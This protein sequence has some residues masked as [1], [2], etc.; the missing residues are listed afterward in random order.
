MAK[1]K[2]QEAQRTCEDC[3]H[4]YACNMW[5]IGTLHNTDASGCGIYTTVKDSA[6]YLIGKMDG[7]KGVAQVKWERDKAIEQ[8][9]H[10]PNCGAKIEVK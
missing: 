3:I 7:E 1:K 2:K 5:N 9:P 10:C 6:A 4:E 8:P